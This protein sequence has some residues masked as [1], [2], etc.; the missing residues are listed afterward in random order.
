LQPDQDQDVEITLDVINK[1]SGMM[2]L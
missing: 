2:M 1:A